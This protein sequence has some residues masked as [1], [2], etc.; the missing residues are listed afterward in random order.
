MK[1]VDE[2]KIF[3]QAGDGGSGCMSFRREKFVPRGGPDGGDGGDGGSVVIVA[4]SARLNLIDLKYHSHFQGK[5]GAN[6]QGSGKHG[7][8]GKEILVQVPPGT[9]I[10]DAQTDELL[11]DLT[12]LGQRFVAARGGQGGRG[13]ARFTTSTNRAPRQTDPGREG[14]QRWLKLELKV[15]ADVG[16]VGFPSVGKSTLI[17]ALSNARPKVAAYPFTTLSPHLGTIWVDEHRQVVF[18][19]IPGLIRG[20]HT[21]QGLG[22]KFLRHIERTRMLIHLVDLD[23]DSGRNPWEDLRHL[24]EELAAFNPELVE[25]LQVVAGNKIDLPG[26]SERLEQLEAELEGQTDG[27]LGISAMEKQNTDALLEKVL[28]AL[29]RLDGREPGKP[30]WEGP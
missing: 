11:V 29:N 13:N 30:V 4:D 3:V 15:I 8:G 22:H 28:I 21:G 7:R 16:I 12:D 24:N 6:G 2:V 19:D 18:A 14:E 1:F 9:L 17:R 25:K 26:A 20:A 27:I 5:R 23:P 10:R